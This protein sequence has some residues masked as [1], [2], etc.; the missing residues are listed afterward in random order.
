VPLT[1]DDIDAV[2]LV[3]H[4]DGELTFSILLTRGGL[5]QRLG[6][7]DAPDPAA[8]L[9]RGRTDRCFEDFMAALPESV[10]EGGG[11]FEDEGR[12]G[13]RHDWRF[14]L[15]GGMEASAWNIAYHQGSAGLPDEFADMV[16]RAERLTHHWW[17][18][19]VAEET[20]QP[21]PTQVAA[22]PPSPRGTPVAAAG[23]RNPAPG[24]GRS[25]G[26]TA[27]RRAASGQSDV[28]KWPAASKKRIA[29]AVLLDFSV[30]SV[31]YLY[32][33]AILPDGDGAGPP[34]A[35]LV[36]FA[37]GEFA[38][39]QFVRKSAGYWMLG[40]HAPLG[41]SPRV[42]PAWLTRES[43]VTMIVGVLLVVS[44]VSGLTSWTITSPPTPYFGLPLG[45]VLS[46]LFTLFFAAPMAAAGFLV[47]RLD[48][49]GVWIGAGTMALMLLAVLLG[50]EE[51]PTAG[52]LRYLLV[53]MPVAFGVG[54][55]LTWKRFT[56]RQVPAPVPAAAR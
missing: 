36:L 27:A 35:G 43:L 28:Q 38:L 32:L 54:L 17:M 52:F 9:V 23:A 6:S 25:V 3:L 31:P 10:L 14:E 24:R 8:V 22:A 47:L 39:L 5:T 48:L 26:A 33:R 29:A 49:R 41:S 18:A 42:D 53:L 2:S 50:W 19:Q 34:G 7:S 44:G 11:D 1:K 56:R 45:P 15:G 12:E 37:F 4:V 51:W 20:G 46:A 40:I 21:F 13:M 55:A 16:V 30:L